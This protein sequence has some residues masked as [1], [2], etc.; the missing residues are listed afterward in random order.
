MPSTS[1]VCPFLR[2]RKLIWSW[3]ARTAGP[4]LPRCTVTIRARQVAA[5]TTPSP[6]GCRERWNLTTAALVLG[7]NGPSTASRAPRAFSRYCSER[8]VTRGHWLL[9]PWRSTGQGCKA[10][11]VAVSATAAAAEPRAAR[12]RGRRNG[13]RNGNPGRERTARNGCP[14]PGRGF[15][16]QGGLLARGLI[17]YAFRPAGCYHPMMPISGL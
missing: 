14:S 5:P 1:S 9:G 13:D 6:S 15:D 11:A 16:L 4:V 3:T 10:W 2:L 7:P 8:T 12:R 17:L